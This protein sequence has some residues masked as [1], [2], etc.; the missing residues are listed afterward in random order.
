MKTFS[1]WRGG[2]SG[3]IRVDKRVPEVGHAARCSTTLAGPGRAKSPLVGHG[4]LGQ[5][6]V[7]TTLGA[8][9]PR[10]MLIGLNPIAVLSREVFGRALACGCR[11]NEELSAIHFNGMGLGFPGRFLICNRSPAANDGGEDPRWHRSGGSVA[12]DFTQI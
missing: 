6:L 10:V 11:S 12:P 3:V 2:K 1:H 4:L 5:D 9:K 8:H 7:R